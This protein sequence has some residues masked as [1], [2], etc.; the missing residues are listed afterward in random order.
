MMKH[1][2]IAANQG[3]ESSMKAL[4]GEAYQRSLI[5]KEELG[6]TLRTHQAAVTAM[7]TPERAKAEESLG[8]LGLNRLFYYS[9]SLLI[10]RRAQTAPIVP[11]YHTRENPSD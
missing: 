2:I 5:T 10:S 3:N 6:A 9:S 1:F 8:V 4:M 7:S 11:L